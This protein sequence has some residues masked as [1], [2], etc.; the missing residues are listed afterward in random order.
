MFLYNVNVMRIFVFFDSFGW[1]GFL[2]DN[3]LRPFPYLSKYQSP[4]RKFENRLNLSDLFQK[5]LKITLKNKI[6]H[7][8][9]LFS[10]TYFSG[11]WLT[12]KKNTKLQTLWNF[13]LLFTHT[14]GWMHMD[15]HTPLFST[16]KNP[17]WIEISLNTQQNLKIPP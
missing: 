1:T 16:T 5:S 6:I 3:M 11:W 9:D 8:F 13:N 2:Q 14:C 12:P 7:S 4:R 10:N 17:I 15:R